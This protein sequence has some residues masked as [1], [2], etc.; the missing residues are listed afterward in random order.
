MRASERPKDLARRSSGRGTEARSQQ[1][2]SASSS[3]ISAISRR[4]QGS[5]CETSETSSGVHPWRSAA[6]T[7]N[8][9]S[10]L[11]VE[12]RR[13]SRT[14]SDIRRSRDAGLP[15]SSSAESPFIS[16]SLKVAPIAITSPTDFIEVPR[17]GGA[18]GNFSKAQRGI[19]TTV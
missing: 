5:M 3:T 6:K 1:A 14:G 13:R 8:R 2:S 12:R 9:R 17:V 19:F 16:A 7:A 4:N 15:S 18:S 11:G 10:Q